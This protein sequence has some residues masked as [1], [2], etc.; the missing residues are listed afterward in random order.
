MSATLQ[1]STGPHSIINIDSFFYIYKTSLNLISKYQPIKLIN[2]LFCSSTMKNVIIIIFLSAALSKLATFWHVFFKKELTIF[3]TH[4]PKNEEFFQGPEKTHHYWNKHWHTKQ[5][6]R[7][8]TSQDKYR[9]YD[10]GDL[11]RDTVNSR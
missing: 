2:V 4:L 7:L 8:P 9:I 11:L 6:L 3:L 5:V 1:H 10:I